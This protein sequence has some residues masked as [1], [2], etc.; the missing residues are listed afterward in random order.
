MG[1]GGASLRCSESPGWAQP[2]VTGLGLELGNRG[3]SEVHGAELTVK[4]RPLPWGRLRSVPRHRAAHRLTERN[5]A[6]CVCA[7]M[8]GSRGGQSSCGHTQGW[9]PAWSTSWPPGERDGCALGTVVGGAAQDDTQARTVHES[10][11]H[12]HSGRAGG[13]LRSS[14]PTPLPLLPPRDPAPPGLL[15]Q[16]P[17]QTAASSPQG[18][19]AGRPPWGPRMGCRGPRGQGF[20]RQS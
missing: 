17:R 13:W 4:A 6:S 1:Q 8:P 3:L 14:V 12:T 16:G 20:R 19:A 5:R 7:H 15:S 9:P 2:P 11:I 10:H 18:E